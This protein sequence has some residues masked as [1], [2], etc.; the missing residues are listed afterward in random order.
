LNTIATPAMDHQTV[1]WNLFARLSI[2]IHQHPSSY[3][4]R[5]FWCNCIWCPRPFLSVL[6]EW[7]EYHSFTYLVGNRVSPQP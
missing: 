7:H 6:E 3:N 5:M 1:N 4:V 2:T